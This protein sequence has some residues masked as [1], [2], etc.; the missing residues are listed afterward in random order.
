[1]CVC[2]RARVRACVRVCVLGKEEPVPRSNGNRLSWL[3][4]REFLSLLTLRTLTVSF[5]QIA[6]LGTKKTHN[7][8][9]ILHARTSSI[10]EQNDFAFPLKQNDKRH[11][12][13][14]IAVFDLQIHL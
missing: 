2:V 5:E 12:V 1:M 11:V 3:K 6:Y 10:L 7:I 13:V 9:Q 4:K 14:C 8:T